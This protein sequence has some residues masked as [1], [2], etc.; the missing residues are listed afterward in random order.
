MRSSTALASGPVAA[1]GR[2]SRGG[3]TCRCV[4]WTS[5]RSGPPSWSVRSG[6]T[7]RGSSR[8]AS[9]ATAC[10]RPRRTGRSTLPAGPRRRSSRTLGVI[11]I[12]VHGGAGNWKPEHH[13]AALDGISRAVDAGHA[14]LAAGGEAL[15]A[16]Q[17]AVVVLEDDPVFNA[18]RGAALDE[19]GRA[20]HDAAIMRGAD[21]AAGAVAALSGIRNP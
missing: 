14:I 3:W 11:T 5:D 4:T 12:V 15:A 13:A 2:C 10:W 1:R 7:G 18:G 6:S 21:R 19:R 20:L 9:P 8:R 16:V 17:A